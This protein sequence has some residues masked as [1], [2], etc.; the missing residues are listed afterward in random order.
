MAT[1]RNYLPEDY[2]AVKEILEEAK[3]FYESWHSPENL[4]AM[5]EKDPT[6]IQLVLQD[7]V[8][9]CVLIIPF[10]KKV[11]YFFSLAI[12]REF[13]NKGIATQLMQHAEELMKKKGTTEFG[14]YVSST[15]KE[16]I[17]FYKRKNFQTSGK[18]YIYMWK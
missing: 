2:E 4:Y 3:L 8:I 5:I 12:K 10:G 15:N 6:S 7:E 11:A 14:L 16:L 17:E 13:R 1:F 9:G 18:E